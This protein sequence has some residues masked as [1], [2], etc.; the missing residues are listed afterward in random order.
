METLYADVIVPR[1]I[2][3]AFTYRVPAT[4]AQTIAIGRRVLVPFGRSVLEGVVISLNDHLA[5]E[6]K[7]ASIKEILSLDHDGQ[8]STLP[9]TLFELSRKI[10]DY[11]VAPWGQCLR[12][13]LPTIATRKTARARYVVTAEGRAALEAGLCPDHLQPILEPNCPTNFRN[14]VLDT[15]I[16]STRK[17][18]ADRCPHQQVVDSAHAFE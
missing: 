4:L 8:V 13:I 1:H 17:H 14:P 2:A 6:I 10:A 15:S 16:N 5:T 12:L 18:R 7:S 11:Y 9:P 3:K